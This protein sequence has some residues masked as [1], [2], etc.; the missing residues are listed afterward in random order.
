MSWSTLAENQENGNSAEMF[1]PGGPGAVTFEGT[2]GSA[3]VKLQ[4]ARLSGGTF[5]DVGLN[6]QATS[7]KVSG[8]DIPEGYLRANV[9]G[10]TGESLDV[11][12]KMNVDDED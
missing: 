1:W 4:F 10:G 5:L 8:F 11:F 3:T 2:F 6:S 9:S 7:A 12:V